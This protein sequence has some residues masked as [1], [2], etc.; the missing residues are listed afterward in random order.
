MAEIDTRPLGSVRAALTHFQQRA[1]HHSRFSPDRNL[2]EIEI[3]TKE[4]A[5]CRMQLEVKE[6]EKIQANL[7]LESLQNAMQESSD[8]RM[9]ARQQS[10]ASEECKALRDE[11][12]VVRGELDAVRSSNSFLL[13]EIE[14]M[15]TRMILEK[16]SIR[17]SL[18]HVLQINES[19]L[20]SAVAAIRAEEERSVF[21]QEITL[22]FL[23]SD[24]NRE[25][26]DRQVEMIKNLESELMAKT[27][28]IAYLQSQLQ[29]VKEHCISSEIIAGNQEQQAEASLTLGN[30][31]AEAVVVAGGGFV[32]V[33]SKEDDGGGEEFY[34]KEIEHDQQQAAGAAGLA[35]ADGYVLVAKS[36]GG[37]ADLKGKLEAARAEIG[38]LRF[39]LEEAVRRAELAEEAKAALERALREEIQRKAQPRNTPSLTTT[40]T[41]PAKPPL[42]EPR[43]GDGRPLPGGCL[44]LGKVLNMKYK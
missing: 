40:T 32:A 36:D 16:E 25:V 38:D 8:N 34:T 24:K 27:V 22:E 30:G 44:T 13:R 2:Q 3:L 5:S 20:S 14:L 41:T 23:S 35:V 11:L 18:N 42:T 7:K 15:E 28:E 6:N 39:S 33:I 29:Q 10:E 31:D 21:F 43:G 19:V 1:D 17:D 12:T 4:L 26:I 9:I 37:D